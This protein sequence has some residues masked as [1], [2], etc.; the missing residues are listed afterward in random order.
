MSEEGAPRVEPTAKPSSGP[1]AGLLEDPD[2]EEDSV[3]TE[4]DVL[5]QWA[6]VATID[7]EKGED[8]AAS[9]FDPNQ[10]FCGVEVST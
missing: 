2:E 9:Q 3:G 8:L 10:D 4:F 1:A 5:S 6:H 7:P